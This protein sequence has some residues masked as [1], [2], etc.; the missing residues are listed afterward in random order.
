MAVNWN[1]GSNLTTPPMFGCELLLNSA[2]LSIDPE[3]LLHLHGQVNNNEYSYTSH[4]LAFDACYSTSL[5]TS[6]TKHRQVKTPLILD[7]WSSELANHPDRSFAQYILDGIAN[8]FR[9]GFNRHHPL[10]RPSNAMLTQNPAVISEYLQREVSLGRME[11]LTPLEAL[12]QGVHISPIGAIPKKHKPGKWRL[13]VDLSSPS[14]ASVNDGISPE[15][16]SLRYTTV[17]HLSTLI[18]Q[19]GRGA[20]LVKADIQEAYRMIPIHPQD[21]PLL[22]VEWG[23][24]VYVDLALPFGLRSAP[25]IFTAVADALQWIL[26]QKGIKLSL[27]YLDDFVIVSSSLTDANYQKEVLLSTCDA[28][29]VPLEPSKLEGPTT[30]LSFLGIEFDTIALQ[31]CL[32]SN[33]LLRLKRELNLA[34][35]RKSIRKQSLQSLT[36]LLQH[37]TKV[38][39]P[40]RP[41]LRRLHA[42]QSVGSFPSHQIRLNL[43]ARADIVWWHTFMERWN[44][45][46]LLWSVGIH[47]PDITVFS[48]ASG[49]W[50]CGAFYSSHWFHM[51]WPPHAQE[52]S[53]AVKELFPVVIAAAL[54]GKLWSGCLVQFT[55]D[56]AAVVQVL[57]ATYSRESHLMHLIRVLVFLA[58]H[59]N[60]WFTACHITG[61]K[62]SLADALSRNNASFFLSQVCQAQRQPSKIPSPLIDLLVCNIT[63]TSTAWIQLFRTTLEQL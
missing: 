56:N 8:G 21:Q 31:L 57:Q 49:S 37:A 18:L 53:I 13:I 14:N 7:R 40:G 62:N 3:L 51:Q 20:F 48:D 24:R 61:N 10:Q 58:S 52:F 32:P 4:L 47:S 12:H 6:S 50:G 2:I 26:I 41:F 35:S 43:A 63:W 60:F 36:G 19:E 30:S 17:D 27:H 9:I 23:N 29:G 39:R 42:L 16:S 46:S 1:E 22:G 55:V 5:S 34:I 28:L 45:L 44:G 38:I 59:F 25:K 54:Y 11:C 15:L 33:K